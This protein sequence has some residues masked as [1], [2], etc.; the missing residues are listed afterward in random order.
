[1]QQRFQQQQQH[2]GVALDSIATATTPDGSG[3]AD[4]T[5]PNVVTASANQRKRKES[6]PFIDASE[7]GSSKKGRKRN[8]NGWFVKDARVRIM[9]K[10]LRS[11]CDMIQRETLPTD[12]P[13]TAWF[14]GQLVSGNSGKNYVVMVDILPHTN[15]KIEATKKRLIVVKDGEEELQFDEHTVREMEQRNLEWDN[16][17]K[18]AETVSENNFVKQTQEALAAATQFVLE[19]NKQDKEQKVEWKIHGDQEHIEGCE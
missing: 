11:C 16:E 6:R 17:G 5:R 14:F 7:R 19:L 12:L 3:T 10:D 13:E 9:L 18:S 4:I 15:N 2:P 1:M 8:K